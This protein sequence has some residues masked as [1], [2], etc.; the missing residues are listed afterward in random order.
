MNKYLF[1]N[2]NT[3]V[4]SFDMKLRKNTD[5]NYILEIS[6][7]AGTNILQRNSIIFHTQDLSEA[8][9][10][11]VKVMNELARNVAPG[12]K[13]EG[14]IR[15]VKKGL[16]L[17]DLKEEKDPNVIAPGITLM[18]NEDDDEDWLDDSFFE[19][20]YEEE[21]EDYEEECMC[22][23]CEHE[24]PKETVDEDVL[25]LAKILSKILKK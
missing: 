7:I 10:K 9:N 4:D 18:N 25:E 12:I 22:D 24:E 6:A 1:Q 23:W 2:F 5:Q 3:A 13:L 16:Q 20:D 21:E 15:T 8:V 14:D 17:S 11:T 19:E